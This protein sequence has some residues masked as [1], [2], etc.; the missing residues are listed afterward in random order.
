MKE[1]LK[2]G[3]KLALFLQEPIETINNLLLCHLDQSI[4]TNILGKFMISHHPLKQKYALST[5]R[6][7][8]VKP[9]GMF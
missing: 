8:R 7:K 2:K 4:W 3:V 1:F 9:N 5:K 6:T